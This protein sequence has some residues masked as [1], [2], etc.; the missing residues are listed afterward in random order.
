MDS[1]KLPLQYL[2][3]SL[4][5]IDH[6]ETP[7]VRTVYKGTETIS[8]LGTKIWDNVP[9]EYKKLNNLNSLWKSIKKLTAEFVKPM[10]MVLVFY[11]DNSLG[12]WK[13]CN[14]KSFFF[15]YNTAL[16]VIEKYFWKAS[17]F[18]GVFS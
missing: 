12:S 10:W 13:I 18:S 9:E 2:A 6:F 14:F 7:L 15:S 16:K 4:I 3:Y 11:K 17:I 8:Y 5:N 1:I